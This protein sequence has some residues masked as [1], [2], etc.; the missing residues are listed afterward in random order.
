MAIMVAM[1]FFYYVFLQNTISDA[2]VRYG[3]YVKMSLNYPVRSIVCWFEYSVADQS[4]ADL[5]VDRWDDTLEHH[6]GRRSLVR[7]FG[8]S[9]WPP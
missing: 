5:V 8:T 6:L 3:C 4:F 7:H 1:A 2:D 9:S